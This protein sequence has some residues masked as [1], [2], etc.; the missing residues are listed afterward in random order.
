MLLDPLRNDVFD[1][2]LQQ[3]MAARA[4]EQCHVIDIGAFMRSVA[5]SDDCSSVTVA[6]SGCGS[7]LLAMMAIRSGAHR[8]TA[9]EMVPDSS[10]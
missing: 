7:G 2:A 3:C 6:G 4:P 10:W 5:T 9:F 1:R 8:V